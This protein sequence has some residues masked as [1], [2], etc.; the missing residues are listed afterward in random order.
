VVLHKQQSF[1]VHPGAA[2]TLA[3]LVVS[4]SQGVVQVNF[5]QVV[6]VVV[7][8][9]VVVIIRQQSLLSQPP[10][11][12]VPTLSL[13][14]SLFAW[15]LSGVHPGAGHVYDAQVGYTMG[16]GFGVVVAHAQQS[17]AVQPAAGQTCPPQIALISQ[18]FV[19]FP[20]SWNI[21]QVVGVVVTIRVVVVSWQQSV[22]LHPPAGHLNEV[23]V[24]SA[25]HQVGHVYVAQVGV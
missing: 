18:G 12:L 22:R 21:L 16:G 8:T 14:H 25:S 20:A 5:A 7:G 10:F 3:S 1:D 17:F 11:G 2:Q 13:R 23:L 19:H 9:G 6:G 24:A 4:F 15:V